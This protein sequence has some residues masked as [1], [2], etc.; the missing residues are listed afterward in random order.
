MVVTSDAQDLALFMSDDDEEEDTSQQ[1]EPSMRELA[2]GAGSGSRSGASTDDAFECASGRDESEE[3]D[4]VRLQQQ[5]SQQLEP[6]YSR[7]GQSIDAI[8]GQIRPNGN[9]EC[10][11]L[12]RDMVAAMLMV[13]YHCGTRQGVGRVGDLPTLG[14]TARPTNERAD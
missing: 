13:L 7:G 5:I 12:Y 2:R 3:N 11:N 9:D 10:V 4:A 1:D 14:I 6:I 8:L